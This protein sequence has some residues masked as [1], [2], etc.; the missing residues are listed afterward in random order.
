[1]RLEKASEELSEFRKLASDSYQSFLPRPLLKRT[2]ETSAM[3]GVSPDTQKARPPPKRLTIRRLD[4][5]QTS[6][7][8]EKMNVILAVHFFM[9]V[10]NCR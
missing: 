9:H 7:A 10:T 4:F 3:V 2:K 1:M 8:G 6:S 5:G